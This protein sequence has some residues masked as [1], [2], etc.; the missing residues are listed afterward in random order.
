M[1]ALST[2]RD[3]Y[4]AAARVHIPIGR[5]ESRKGGN[6]INSA[7]ILNLAGVILRVAALGEKA[8]LV[9]QPL[10]NRAAYENTALKGIL[11]IVAACARGD[12]C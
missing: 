8:H 2:A 10:N 9:A 11:H 4:N 3:T 6:D 1:G 5:A 7:R 12:R